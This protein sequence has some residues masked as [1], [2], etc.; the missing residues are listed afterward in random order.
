MC[1]VLQISGQREFEFPPKKMIISA[2]SGN[3]NDDR[4]TDFIMTPNSSQRD[5][6]QL[7]NK[8]PFNI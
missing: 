1:F 3:P 6:V 5:K 2:T 8:V 4:G 7:R